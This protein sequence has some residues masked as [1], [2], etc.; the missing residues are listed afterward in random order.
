MNTYN[1]YGQHLSCVLNTTDEWVK[2]KVQYTVLVISAYA[3]ISHNSNI[4]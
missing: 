1:L 4:G 3:V 2:Q